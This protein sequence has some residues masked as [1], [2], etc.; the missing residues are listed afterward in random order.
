VSLSAL[1]SALADDVRLDI[2]RQLAARGEHKCGTLEL[3]V[4]KATRSHHLRVLREAGVT[5]TRLAGTTRY[6]SLRRA[7]LDAHYPGL[8]AA[9]LRPAPAPAA[10]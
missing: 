9:V 3:S 5:H 6:V 7:E 8:L 4:T 10:R 1:L 2:V